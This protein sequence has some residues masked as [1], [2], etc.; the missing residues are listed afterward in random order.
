MCVACVGACVGA[1]VCV[2]MCVQCM[3]VST[4]C[5]AFVHECV[6]YVCMCDACIQHVHANDTVYVHAHIHTHMCI[7][8]APDST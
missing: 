6:L 1:C 2:C 4:Y 5:Q 8:T 3:H 7:T